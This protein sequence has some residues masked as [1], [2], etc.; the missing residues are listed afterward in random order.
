MRRLGIIAVLCGWMSLVVNAAPGPWEQPAAALAGQIADILGPGQARFT[1]RNLSS[2]SS[3][4]LPGIQHILEQ[5]LKARG[6]TLSGDESANS[7]RVTFSENARRLW[8]AEVVEGDQTQVAMVELPLD[9]PARAVA[10]GEILL[11]KDTIFTAHEPVLSALEMTNS[12][13]VLEPDQIAIYARAADGWQ[14]R[15]RVSIAGA[16][17]VRD[18][19]GVVVPSEDGTGFDAWLPGAH[20]TGTFSTGDWAVQCG[21]SDDP[22]AIVPRTIVQPPAQVTAA[23][24]AVGPPAMKAFYNAARNYF[25]GV[26]SPGVGLEL[27]AFYSAVLVPRAVGNA[28]LLIAGI[29]G[30]VHLA[31]DG[32]FAPVA[33]TRDWGSDLGVIHSGCGAGTQLI[34]SGSG[35]AT[36]DSLRAYELP[37]LEAVPVSTPLAMP[38]TVMA[39]WPAPDARSIYAAVR[40]TPDQYEVDHVAALCN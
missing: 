31:E 26:V 10:A 12:L 7:V 29:D 17:L 35:Q 39:I 13:I 15:K 21:T 5:D 37:A 33:G 4:E 19:R 32:A 8:V 40:T 24:L 3:S 27:P 23:A 14:E 25:T 9:Q 11:R 20:C 6:V 36:S 2:I 16:P 38:G 30:K 34:A 18:P 22:W 28:A 1:L